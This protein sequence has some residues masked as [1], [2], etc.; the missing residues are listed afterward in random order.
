MGDIADWA[1]EQFYDDDRQCT[2]QEV[3]FT[4]VLAETFKAWLIRFPMDKK[5]ISQECWLPKS[6]CTIDMKNKIIEVPEWLINEKDLW[7][8]VE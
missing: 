2:F 6:Q 5:L 1:S 8:H 3:I 7:D 4:S